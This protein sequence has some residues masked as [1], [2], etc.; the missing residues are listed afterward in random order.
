M[1]KRFVT[2]ISVY[3]IFM[4]LIHTSDWQDETKNMAM[5][6]YLGFHMV[7]MIIFARYKFDE[8]D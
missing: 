3:A 1:L 2:Q 4:S 8:T 5:L 6:I 7:G